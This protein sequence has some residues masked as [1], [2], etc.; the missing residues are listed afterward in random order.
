MSRVDEAFA[1]DVRA[2]LDQT[3]RKGVWFLLLAV[4]LLMATLGVWAYFAELEEVTTGEG[5]VIPS[6]QNPDC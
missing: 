4:L 2:A 1:N 5:R 3:S 6:S